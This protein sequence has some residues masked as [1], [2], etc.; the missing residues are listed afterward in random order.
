MSRRRPSVHTPRVRT[1]V[2]KRPTRR[3]HMRLR[4]GCARGETGAQHRSEDD[5]GALGPAQEATTQLRE[6]A[7]SHRGR[8]GSRALRHDVEAGDHRQLVGLR[9]EPLEPTANQFLCLPLG[10]GQSR[11]IVLKAILEAVFPVVPVEVPEAVVLPRLE[12]GV[13]NFLRLQRLR[14]QQVGL[15][16]EVAHLHVEVNPLLHKD[17]FHKASRLLHKAADC[18]LKL[19][20]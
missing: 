2:L 3:N 10:V 12:D 9:L 8:A 7:G 6:L 14:P 20:L 19:L 16:H 4:Q 18:G 13:D 17:E 1:L 5:A 15:D 11:I